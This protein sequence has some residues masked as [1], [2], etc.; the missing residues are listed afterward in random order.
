MAEPSILNNYLD[1]LSWRIK[2]NS[3]QAF[4]LQG[5]NNFIVSSTTR[6]FWIEEVY[7]EHIANAYK[8]G[9]VHIHDLGSLSA[10]CTGWDLYDFLGTGFTGVPGKVQ[11]AAPKHLSS[12][13][14]Q[15]CNFLYTI[16]GETA[17][18]VA[19]SNFD[20]LLAPFIYYDNLTEKQVKQYLQ[21]FVFNM[22]V[23]TR[24]GFQCPFSNITL[25]F[26][27]PSTFESRPVLVGGELQDETYGEF[28]KEMDLLNKNLFEVLSEGDAKGRIF[29]FP[30]P[31]V[32]ITK[33]F[34]WDNPVLDSFWKSTSKY[35]IPYFSNL[36]NSDLSPED[37]LSMCPLAPDTKVFVRENEERASVLEIKELDKRNT[38]NKISYSV[39]TPDGWK[40]ARPVKMPATK[41]YNVQFS[42]GEM[43]QMGENHLQ[44]VSGCQTLKASQ[45]KVGMWAPF[46][47][48]EENKLNY[49]QIV[50]IEEVT[51]SSIESL[52]CMEVDSDDHLFM[53][54]NGL[55]THNCRLRM[56][57][58][59][60]RNK[61]GGLFGSNP[62]TGSI[63]VCTINLPRTAYLSK[64][65]KEAFLSRVGDLMDLSKESLQIKREKLEE[66][67]KHGLY[68]YAEFY[69][70]NIKARDKKYWSNHFS[71]I[72]LVGMHEACLNLLGKG[73]DSEQGR[74]LTIELLSFMRER[75]G[76]YQKETGCYF[77]LEATP[78]EGTGSRLAFLDK[79]HTPDIIT[80]GSI[81]QPYY[82]NSTQLPVDYKGDIFDVLDHQDEIQALYTGG[83][84]IHVYIGEEQIDPAASK[85][86][87]KK[88]FNKYK[89]PY[90]SLTPTFSICSTHGYLKGLSN[91]CPVCGSECEVYSR[92][93]GYIRPVKG[94]NDGKQLEFSE[95][96]TFS[97][98]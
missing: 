76:G 93:V 82:T 55:I 43:V 91:L 70:R 62:L 3:N 61:G 6:K 54:A 15:L 45:L 71:T 77:N 65:S 53:L 73:I 83:T 87:I 81:E 30:I 4:S 80:S 41:M 10:Y 64:G 17:G 36:V 25:D 28:Q 86:F 13:L 38:N 97:I 19:V 98:E 1:G 49:Y 20:T 94:W 47:K 29:S 37:T 58:S 51:D 56:E 26:V 50:S 72:G 18:A 67:T 79:K 24:V 44:P 84:T 31:T 85:K 12:A 8:E 78:A 68:P 96:K 33:D 63:G 95:R 40:N 34:N 42:N 60:L 23:P 22:N 5:L 14:G 89:L 16:Q 59:E 69:L 90:L 92:V 27:V 57:V 9:D 2:E 39:W 88:I 46:N 7:P 52:Y 21:E 35:G 48:V 11:S 74:E 32:N 66:F 75:I